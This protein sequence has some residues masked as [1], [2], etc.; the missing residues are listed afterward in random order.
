[1]PS[2]VLLNQNT[3]QLFVIKIDIYSKAQNNEI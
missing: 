3:T 2:F 1:M